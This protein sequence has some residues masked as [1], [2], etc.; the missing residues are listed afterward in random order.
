M[1]ALIILG[2]I[3]VLGRWLLRGRTERV[4][5]RTWLQLAPCAYWIAVLV[6]SWHPVPLATPAW[7][8]ATVRPAGVGLAMLAG[9]FAAWAAL[10]LGRYWDPSISALRD[11]RV[12]DD[13]PYGVVRHPIYLG[14]LAFFVG[15][16]LAVV[17]PVVAFVSGGAAAVA[18]L[19]A[20][21]EER[22][23]IERLGDEYRA[24]RRS[25]PMLAPWPR[26]GQRADQ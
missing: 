19:R 18:L 8:D 14:L 16:T 24:Y 22:F 1:R 3:G 17:D 4:P 5:M 7:Y 6:L 21:A 25:V 2:A 13:G 26:P 9:A 20:R 11:H 15:T 12:V 10:H 23:L